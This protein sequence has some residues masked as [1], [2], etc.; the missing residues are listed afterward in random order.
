[1]FEKEIPAAADLGLLRL[2]M[3]AVRKVLV[4]SQEKIIKKFQEFVPM[5]LM[6]R[7]KEV[8]EWMG[9]SANQLKGQSPNI[10]DFVKK[11]QSLKM[12]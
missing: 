7:N 10:D 12:I 8:C 9:N 5:M 4:P 11:S 2:D 1:V 3:S 6:A